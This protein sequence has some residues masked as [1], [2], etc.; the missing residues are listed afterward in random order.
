MGPEDPL[1]LPEAFAGRPAEDFVDSLLNFIT[2]STLLQNLCGG[3]HILDFLTRRPDL[4]SSILPED[5]REW[6]RKR[7]IMD[8]LDVLMRHD[9][10]NWYPNTQPNCLD[11]HLKHD[12]NLPPRTL[13]QYIK[14]VRSHSLN[15]DHLARRPETSEARRKNTLSRDVAVG[16][17]VKKIEEVSH[18]AC[19]IDRLTQEL[20]SH[21]TE[22]THLVDFGSGQNYLGRA[23]ASRPYN[24]QVIAL[25][26]KAHNIT[27]AKK[28][29][30]MARLTEKPL[31][32]RNKKQYRT[33]QTGFPSMPTG[34]IAEQTAREL[35]TVKNNSLETPFVT[36]EPKFVETET[37]P[38]KSSASTE[39]RGSVQYVEYLIKD[40]DLQPVL[41]R[42]FEQPQ[43]KIS[44][45]EG[46][47]V[48]RTSSR[49][50]DDPDNRMTKPVS[51]RLLVVSLHSCGNL[52][53][54]GIRSLL[55]NPTVAAVALV[56]CCYNLVTERLGSP[57]YKLPTLRS[58]HPRLEQTSA[59]FDPHGFPM[60]ER[61][62]QFE[63]QYGKGIRLNITARMMAVQAPQ[64]WGFA[65]SERFFTRHF[66]RALLQRIFLDYGVVEAP[67]R[68]DDLAEGKEQDDPHVSTNPI[69]IGSLRKSC[70]TSFVSYVRGAL[71]KL[72]NDSDFGL[73]VQEKLGSISDEEIRR[74]EHDFM[75][76]KHEISVLWSL[77]AFSASVME[78]VMVIDRWLFL[79]EQDCV[80][81]CWVEPVFSFRHSPRN[82][83]VVGI[84][85]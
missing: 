77:M 11:D 8:I 6:F 30:E 76:K 23:L 36:T 55:L 15:R 52:I 21:D 84:K 68:G 45:S 69:I 79:E 22:I 42:L 38:S 28:Y 58:K 43:L 73:L 29:D 44:F 3:V 74:Y 66:Y 14:A 83:V 64:N 67:K 17:K 41:K 47:K 57:T 18:F 46:D 56:G 65:D 82:L 85:K 59:A 26:S 13:I 53:H 25:E 4:Y 72:S 54:H 33:E 10:T 31:V 34:S 12:D 27:G 50:E 60:S 20:V 37:V 51:P 1:P 81:Q 62:C 32:T 40:G 7:D 2:S 78:A 70:Y 16:M 19:Y 39:E 5:W 75:D 71:Q 80:Q 48:R 63:H 9:L 24:K 49:P 61:L 35:C